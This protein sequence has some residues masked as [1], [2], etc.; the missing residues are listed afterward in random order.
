MRDKLN[1]DNTEG[2]KVLYI[3]SDP[4]GANSIQQLIEL[5][6][7]KG[8]IPGQDLLVFTNN[9]SAILAGLRDFTTVSEN[10]N[11]EV[12]TDFEPDF[13]ITGT[14][15]NSYEHK[16]RIAAISQEI[17]AVAFIDHWTNYLERFQFDGELSLPNQIWVINQVAKQEAVAAGI[18]EEIIVV[19]G[20]PYYQKVESFKPEIQRNQFFKQLNLRLDKKLLVFVSDNIRDSFPKDQMGH[21]ELGFD[22][23]SVL[24]ELLQA[25]VVCSK[26]GSIDLNEYQMIVKLHPRSKED[27]FDS[28]FL[29]VPE[30]FDIQF[31]STVDPLTI[32]YFSD[33]VFGMFSNMVIESLLMG[34][35]TL[36]IQ[37]GEKGKDIF[38]YTDVP[39]TKIVQREALPSAITEFLS[40]Q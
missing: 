28:L 1:F 10:V 2:K 18:P 24:R 20:N 17:P 23:Y 39:V 21:C 38:K 15:N 4:A 22:E 7:L 33:F 25:L 37:I 30:G 14:S 11:G 16:W 36:R 13:L 40:G 19:K 8:K 32:N 29:D 9:P 3:Y 31:I 26:D 5:E 27:K 35:K 34:K 12:F 6:L